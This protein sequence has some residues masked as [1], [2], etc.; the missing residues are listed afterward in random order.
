MTEINMFRHSPDARDVQA[1]EVLFD[2]GDSGDAMFAVVEGNVELSLNG[3]VIEDVGPGGILG[4]M[5]LIN[6]APRTARAAAR[7]AARVVSVDQQR[8]TYLV[9]EHPTF[10]IQV[11]RVMAERLRRADEAASDVAG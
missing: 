7:T 3:V 1:G 8:F 4:E 2:Q 11:M 9:Q 5:A 10:A 6:P